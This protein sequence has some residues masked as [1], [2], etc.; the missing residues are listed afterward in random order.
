MI[1][2]KRVLSAGA[3]MFS[4]LQSQASFAGGSAGSIVIGFAPSSQ[5]AVP[6]VPVPAL[7]SLGLLALAV[8]LAI[9][10]FRVLKNRGTSLT[11]MTVFAGIALA[12]TV[13][14]TTLTIKQ[15]VATETASVPLG[16][17]STGGEVQIND[18]R[19][20][21]DNNFEN[22]CENDVE[23]ISIVDEQTGLTCT[24]VAPSDL[25]P[26]LCEVGVT[27]SGGGG[28]CDI[29]ADCDVPLS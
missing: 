13:A 3:V 15:A 29:P 16:E 20:G 8:L 23:I 21:P 18:L 2:R 28:T 4:L 26:P 25:S 17:C 9:I 5:S 11:M 24:P 14:L 19:S 22:Q 1:N 27:V 10:G 6:V 7:G 12:A